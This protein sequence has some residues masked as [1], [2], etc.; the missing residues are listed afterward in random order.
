MN[1]VLTVYT[2]EEAAEVLRVAPGWLEQQ[3]AAR[4]VPF[5]MLGDCYR[6]TDDHLAQIVRIF[7]SAPVTASGVAYVQESL[8]A[9]GSARV[10]AVNVVEPFGRS[11]PEPRALAAVGGP[12]KTSE[13]ADRGETDVATGVDVSVDP[14]FVDSTGRRARNV[15]RAGYLVAGLCAACTAVLG[16]SLTGVTPMAPSRAAPPAGASAAPSPS[17]SLARMQEVRSGARDRTSSATDRS[18]R[19]GQSRSRPLPEPSG[20]TPT[21]SGS[22][23]SGRGSRPESRKRPPGRWSDSPGTDDAAFPVGS[24]DYAPP[25]YDQSRR[26]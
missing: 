14:I 4:R 20:P 23:A 6:F 5:T 1:A 3:A 19:R 17:A 16:V 25:T 8:P 10:Y 21:A 26:W 12:E 7:E 11:V 15:R 24:E 22:P 9:T 13:D 2:P 18:D